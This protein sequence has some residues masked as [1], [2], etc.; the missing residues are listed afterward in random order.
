MNNL[1]EIPGFSNYLADSEG[2]IYSKN[3]NGRKGNLQKMKGNTSTRGYRR[4]K[5]K[6]DMGIKKCRY[7]HRLIMLAFHGES[8][9]QV[10]HIDGDKINNNPCNLEYCTHTENQRH[11]W[12]T[13]LKVPILGEKS[14]TSKL[15]R[16]EV[17]FI[18]KYLHT[19]YNTER[20]LYLA[21]KYDIQSTTIRDIKYN[22]T[23]KHVT[24]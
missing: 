2:N 9:L 24:I 22:R 14:H 10:N 21:D 13:G 7:I 17:V 18:R 19:E 4:V 3:F 1:K 16:N 23:W 12:R 20:V 6:D 15:K 8:E 11:A 5:I